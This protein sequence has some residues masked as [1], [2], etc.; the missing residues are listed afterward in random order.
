M[1]DDPVRVR[2]HVPVPWRDQVET[3]LVSAGLLIDPEAPVGVSVAPGRVVDEQVD[4]WSVASLP[5]LLVGVWPHA[6]HVGPW[7]VPGQGPCARCVRAATFDEGDL[8]TPESIPAPL[9]SLA[10]GWAARDLADWLRGET[11]S[12]W[13]SSWV[14]DHSPLPQSR[15]WQR[16]PYCGCGWFDPV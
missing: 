8:M 10:A 6:L 12:T 2:L 9:L 13:L 11:P 5:H 15:R 1:Y 7:V 16:H 14:L 4:A 3:T